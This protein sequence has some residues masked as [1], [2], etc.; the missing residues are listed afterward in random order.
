VVLE[1]ASGKFNDDP[2]AHTRMLNALARLGQE[3]LALKK[4]Q[5][6]DDAEPMFNIPDD[7]DV[8][9]LFSHLSNLLARLRNPAANQP[10]SA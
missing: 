6:D 3:A 7:P 1:N 8:A 10:C 2:Q 5:D 4:A 9:T